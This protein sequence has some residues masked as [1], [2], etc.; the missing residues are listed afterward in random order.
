MKYIWFVFREGT[1][2]VKVRN[3]VDSLLASI[4]PNLP[5][6]LTVATIRPFEAFVGVI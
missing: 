1:N 5:I 6:S 2:K 4:H 3:P